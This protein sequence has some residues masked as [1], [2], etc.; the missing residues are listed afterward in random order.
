MQNAR[1]LNLKVQQPGIDG[2]HGKSPVSPQ[3]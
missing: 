1:L 2:R 3:I